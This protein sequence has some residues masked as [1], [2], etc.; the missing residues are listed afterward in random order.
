MKNNYFFKRILSTVLT[1]MFASLMWAAT[2]EVDGIAYTTLSATEV[3]VTQSSQY[4]YE[5]AIVIPSTVTYDGTTYNVISIGEWA[6]TNCSSLTS[7][8]IPNGVT[9]IGEWAFGSCSSLTSVVIPNS[10]TSIGISA[11]SDCSSLTSIEIPNSVTSIDIGAFGGCSSL[12]SVEIPS[13]VTSIYDNPF[14]GCSSLTSITVADDNPIYDSREACNAIIE[15]ASNTLITGCL[16]T[17]IP[18]S[19]TSI[20]WATFSGCSS[21]TSIKIPNS[22]TSIGGYAFIA[23]SALTSIEIPNSVTSIGE[24]A[25]SD[26]SALTSIEIPNSVTSIGDRAFSLCSSLTSIEIPNSV[27]SIGNGAFYRC[28]ALTSVI[29]YAEELPT[30]GGTIFAYTPTVTLYVPASALEAYKAA[31]QWKEFRTILPIDEYVNGIESTAVEQETDATYYTLDGV[32]VKNPTKKGIYIR[33]G[34]KVLFQ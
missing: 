29:C 19:V 4:Q 32:S 22:V 21:L 14:A 10:V 25:F 7:V 1:L 31:E 20:G 30:L 3:A 15:T 23:C 34:K 33:N 18:S 5:G 24:G 13:S 16:N 11:F 2:F 28:Y 9:S 17:V 12:T 8:E 26:C 27:T 6:F